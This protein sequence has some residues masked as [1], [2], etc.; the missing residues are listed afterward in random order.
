MLQSV[1]LEYFEQRLDDTV[2]RT[3][4]IPHDLARFGQASIPCRRNCPVPQCIG[5]DDMCGG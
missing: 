2:T 5:S 4:K 1:K 3:E